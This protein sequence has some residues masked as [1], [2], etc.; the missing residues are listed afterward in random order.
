MNC[1]IYFIGDSHFGHTNI[2]KYCNRPFSSAE[3][4]NER[5]IAN[6]KFT[7]KPEDIVYFL[8]DFCLNGIYAPILRDL[9]FE[10]MFF[11]EG[12]HDPLPKLKALAD[13]RVEFHKNLE[14]SLD[15]HT[16]FL[17]HNPMDASPTLPT[18]CGHVHEQWTFLK[19]G[20]YF[21]EYHKT[22]TIK[23]KAPQ[24]ILN[25]SVDVH[26]FTPVPVIRVIAYFVLP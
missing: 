18:I 26:N 25:V 11:I 23:K 19:K 14:V 7:I 8:G 12:N 24:P 6:W 20:Q 3:E 5:I 1:V 13:P 21:A 9:P 16:F 17:T 10:H 22:M 2:I 4:M 15:G